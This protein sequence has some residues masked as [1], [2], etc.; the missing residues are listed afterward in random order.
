[1]STPT[2]PPPPELSGR[3]AY[4]KSRF[5]AITIIGLFAVNIAIR[6]WDAVEVLQ[7]NDE[8]D[9][10]RATGDL[11]TLRAWAQH[12]DTAAT[13]RLIAVIATW[14]TAAIALGFWSRRVEHIHTEAGAFDDRPMAR[15]ARRDGQVRRMRSFE[16]TAAMAV[17]QLDGRSAHFALSV[18]D[19]FFGAPIVNWWIRLFVLTIVA[20]A[21]LRPFT[22]VKGVTTVDEFKSTVTSRGILGL[23]LTLS[24][25]L[26]G[27]L[28]AIT[29]V[30]IGWGA[31]KPGTSP[32]PE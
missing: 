12:W 20:S 5:M 32:Q 9:R 17:R 8:F 25:T 6:A 18:K 14:I 26:A 15:R 21:V 30:R 29:L 10:R 19:R 31:P 13:Q 16:P 4:T 23:G 11:D 28:G 2:S 27:L 7:F 22:S 3:T 24:L 1:M